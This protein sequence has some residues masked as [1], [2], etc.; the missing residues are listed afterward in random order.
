M[1]DS[2]RQ[3]GVT[4]AYNFRRWHKSPRIILTFLLAFIV[5]F[6]LTDRL[7]GYSYHYDATLQMFEPFIWAF[8]DSNSIL[9][10]S[11]FVLLLFS[12]MPF[13]TPGVPFF[14]MRTTRMRWLAGQFLYILG[15]GFLYIGFI[16]LSTVLLCIRN[17]F[18][19]NVWSRTAAILQYSGD[20]ERLSVPVS[21]RTLEMSRPYAC[22]AVVFALMLLYF[23]VLVFLMLLFSIWKGRRAGMASVLLFS[24]YGFLLNPQNLIKLMDL[25]QQLQYKA[26][27]LAGWVSPLNQATYS[28]HDFGYDRLPKLWQTFVIFAAVLLVL[29]LLTALAVRNYSFAFTGTGKER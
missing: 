11:L 18:T 5:C 3:A 15:A 22:T 29:V 25:P 27:V 14:L 12:D 17:A 2:Y 21:L 10:V 1:A 6:L 4:A 24:L 16:L 8:G 7:L 19:G 20:G 23:L 9:L 28:M 13:L 26:W